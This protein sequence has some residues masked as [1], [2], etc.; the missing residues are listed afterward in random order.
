MCFGKGLTHS[1]IHTSDK[2]PLNGELF[3]RRLWFSGNANVKVLPWFDGT[4]HFVSSPS[5]RKSLHALPPRPLW[6]STNAPW[7]CH[8]PHHS[9]MP[10]WHST[11]W[12][13]CTHSKVIDLNITIYKI[14]LYDQSF[15]ASTLPSVPINTGQRSFALYPH[16][17][18]I[19]WVWGHNSATTKATQASL[20]T[21]TKLYV[22]RVIY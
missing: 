4:I 1:L 2:F 12:H 14:T 8:S 7:R 9:P 22:C 17:T 6:R 3:L 18:W 5:P 16:F 21:Q 20:A 15:Q 10:T 11:V 19:S 13:T